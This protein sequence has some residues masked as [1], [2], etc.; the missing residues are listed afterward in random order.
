MHV[1]F[2]DLKRVYKNIKT[3]IDGAIQTVLE[4]Q[5]FILGQAVEEFENKMADYCNVK[6]SSR[7]GCDNGIRG[8][9]WHNGN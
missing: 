5:Q 4:S 7:N 1:P 8:C 9:T 3:E 2:L 6:S